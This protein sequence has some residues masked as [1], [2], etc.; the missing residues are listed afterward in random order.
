[1]ATAFDIVK[2]ALRR[3]SIVAGTEDPSASDAADVLQELNRTLKRYEARGCIE[4]NPQ[5]DGLGGEWTAGDEYLQAIEDVLTARIAKPFGIQPD[6]TVVQD[7]GRGDRLILR[8]FYDRQ[9][10][11]VDTAL[12]ISRMSGTGSAWDGVA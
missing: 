7:A 10:Y 5:F 8:H 6:A 11:G 1:M 2:A 3:L 4:V 12:T 9:T